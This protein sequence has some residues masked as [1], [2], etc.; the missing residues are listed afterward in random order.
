MHKMLIELLNCMHCKP[1]TVFCEQSI[2]F[3]LKHSTEN[4]QKVARQVHTFCYEK[5]AINCYIFYLSL[6]VIV[7]SLILLPE[8]LTFFGWLLLIIKC[9]IKTTSPG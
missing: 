3:V 6:K 9:S 4:K 2:V 8:N 5:D 7:P 1:S